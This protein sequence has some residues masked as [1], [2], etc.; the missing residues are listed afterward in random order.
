[1]ISLA[2]VIALHDQL[3]AVNLCREGIRDNNLLQSAVDGQLWFDDKFRQ[4][5]HVAYCINIFHIFV[6]GNKRTTFLILKE[7]REEGIMFND[8]KLSDIILD[9][10]EHSSSSNE[11]DFVAAITSCIIMTSPKSSKEGIP[12]RKLLLVI[13]VQN[14]FINEHSK[15]LPAKLAAY[16]RATVYADVFATAYINDEETPCYKRLGWKGCMTQDEQDICPELEGLYT[17]VFTKRT[18]NAMTMSLFAAIESGNYDEIHIVGISST[19]CVLATAYEMFDRG[20]NIYVI[21]SLCSITGSLPNYQQ[22]ADFILRENL[23]CLDIPDISAE[24]KIITLEDF[25]LRPKL[26]MPVIRK[27]IVDYEKWFKDN[28]PNGAHSER[29][30]LSK[31]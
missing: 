17:K 2:K 12:M 20:L 11:E 18:Y 8:D 16:I 22:A 14:G 13:D 23:P 5:C 6:D 3:Q 26:L 1:M 28:F 31:L 25:L 19:C 4:Y 21:P 27:N 30:I 29:E 10:A 24:E 9:T 7:L 15:W